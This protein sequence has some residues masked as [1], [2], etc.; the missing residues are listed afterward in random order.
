MA[1]DPARPA[2]PDGA[3]PSM[4]EILASIRRILNDDDAP[5]TSA[6]G[7]QTPAD[8]DV[9]VLDQSMM[10]PAAEPVVEAT[11]PEPVVEP[12]PQPQPM[13]KLQPDAEPSRLEM[14]ARE[15]AALEMEDTTSASEADHWQ[16]PVPT[17]DLL[18]PEA[19]AA[20]ASS[21]GTLV[22]T[23]TAG[24]GTQIYAGG[25]TLEDIVRAELRQLLKEWLDV[26]LP[27]M[28]ERLVRIEIERVVGH[29]VP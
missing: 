7:G 22:R 19:A 9:L 26:N 13:A 15:M 28:V 27:P 4:E 2:M 1:N 8:D 16:P 10:V 17:P 21:V 5:A 11:A 14:P 12:Q 3:D 29:A 23:L 24:R 18:A 20:A 6:D 25:P